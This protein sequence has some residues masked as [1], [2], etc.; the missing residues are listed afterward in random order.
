[1]INGKDRPST[2]PIPTF[3]HE[4]KINSEHADILPVAA[5]IVT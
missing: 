4:R 5:P 1:M 2:Q 3:D